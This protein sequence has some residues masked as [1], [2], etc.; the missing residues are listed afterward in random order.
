MIKQLTGLVPFNYI[1]SRIFHSP[2][3]YSWILDKFSSQHFINS[4]VTF[5]WLKHIPTTVLGSCWCRRLRNST[6]W[7]RETWYLITHLMSVNWEVGQCLCWWHP[8]VVTSH[9]TGAV[10][11]VVLH[12]LCADSCWHLPWQETSENCLLAC[13][14]TSISNCV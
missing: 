7:Q 14:D 2:N 4:S 13:W 3:N 6:S 8:G 1:P 12:Q 9:V 10:T 5:E 11:Q